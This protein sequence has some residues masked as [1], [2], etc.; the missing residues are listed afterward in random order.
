MKTL[1]CASTL[2][3]LALAPASAPAQPPGPVAIPLGPHSSRLEWTTEVPGPDG[4]RLKSHSMVQLASGLN[5]WSGTE[6][7]PAQEVIRITPD[8][9][10]FTEG[11]YRVRF[12]GNANT[13]GAIRVELPEG[14]SLV[15]HVLGVALTD[16]ASGRSIMLGQMQ[17]CRAVLWSKNQILF[18]DCLQGL[19]ADL[20]YTCR[21]GVFSQ[22]LLILENIAPADWGMNEQH[23]RIEVFTEFL[24]APEPAQS[25]R[26]LR[27]QTDPLLRQAMVAPDFVDQTLDWGVMKMGVGRA[28]P[29]PDRGVQDSVFTGKTWEVRDGRRVLIEAV[30]FSSVK[31]RLAALPRAAAAHRPAA[32]LKRLAGLP[33]PLVAGAK[34][35]VARLFPPA[36]APRRHPTPV[37]L[38]A[39]AQP[40]GPALAIDYDL[41]GSL[42]DWVFSGDTVYR[43][44]GPVYLS[45]TNNVIEPGTVIK[46]APN[47]GASL[48]IN[49]GLT[50]PD[51]PYCPAYLTAED[52]NTLGEPWNENEP[53]DSYASIALDFTGAAPNCLVQNLRIGYAQTA[54]RRTGFDIELRNVH[55]HHC[56]YGLLPLECTFAL[57]NAL[58]WNVETV[59]AGNVGD[60]S[61][62]R[63]EN[64]TLHRVLSLRDDSNL[65]LS[66]Y[67]CLGVT[68]ENWEGGLPGESNASV[69]TF[70]PEDV[71]AT[72]GAG[73]HY[74][75]ADSPYRN[76]GSTN[77]SAFT[78]AE[79][80]R[81]TTRAP[82]VLTNV[83]QDTVLE[84][85]V[86]RDFDTP[87]LGYHF[88]PLDFLIREVTVGPNVTLLAT[89]GVVLGLDYATN[90]S[91]SFG[92]LLQNGR[93][94]SQ[95][96]A[97]SHNR[98]VRAHN[99][100]ERSNG[101][102]ENRACLYDGASSAAVSEVRWRFTEFG[103][104]AD[105]GN[106]LNTGDKLR[107]FEASHSSFR[108]AAFVLATGGQGPVICGLTN[109]L[110]ERGF[111]QLGY[112]TPAAGSVVQVRN[113]LF[114]RSVHYF[115]NPTN[116]WLVADNL[117]DTAYVSD[118][119]RGVANT[120][121]AY[122]NSTH[123][124][125]SSN[126][127]S[128][129][130]LNNLVY[131]TGPLGTNYLGG[132]EDL[133]NKGSC[134]AAN[135]ALFHFTTATNQAPETN[136]VVDVGSHYVAL[137][138]NGQPLDSDGDGIPNHLD[139]GN[140]NG[141]EDNG[142]QGWLTRDPRS[143]GLT[144]YN[145]PFQVFTPL[146]VP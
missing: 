53:E 89:N 126:A 48:I 124:F 84:P 67:N 134:G 62:G 115:G 21:R 14:Q 18:Q 114:R 45:G 57:R 23:V 55:L 71:F 111:S 25:V 120:H 59:L 81:S 133:V 137:D 41:S 39:Q 6:W 5:Y 19:R 9:A 141:L 105:D 10:E 129:I 12:A 22:D 100:Q 97:L 26:F 144:P 32:G 127:T 91:T 102:P 29:I 3:A 101:N 33:N 63:W 44:V 27:R 131:Q 130:W 83:T 132:N 143:H 11:L 54:I 109:C 138:V 20:L 73:S 13:R 85:V 118:W 34:R 87:D 110:W 119:G 58:V 123:L 116:N 107:A 47:V 86:E 145:R 104:L 66:L 60:T 68:V 78:R 121:N 43:V 35:A 36:P 51:D 1:L 139:D 125:A 146:R 52:D 40:L 72:A 30:E 99:V 24:A 80:A 37:T 77:L 7:K 88:P 98:I 135:V 4:P 117:F 92:L 95:G 38:L 106:L 82:L 50:C 42:T 112:S 113:C 16:C 90:V 76:T 65:E 69:Y 74:L 31:A 8:G 75:R 15:S 17:D 96:N 136:T 28:F 93:F 56:V 2:L 94:L 70:T 108:N 46:F 103:Q 61:V 79:L 122:F 140:G 142:E 49:G 64:V 128:V